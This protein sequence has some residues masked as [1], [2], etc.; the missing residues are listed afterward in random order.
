MPRVLQYWHAPVSVRRELA[1]GLVEHSRAEH[2]PVRMGET[3][4]REATYRLPHTRGHFR[5]AEPDTLE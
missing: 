2:E 5:L 3:T 1:D 4:G